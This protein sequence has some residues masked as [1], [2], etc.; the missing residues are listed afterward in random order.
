MVAP[1]SIDELVGAH[2][3]A[4]ARG[5]GLQY[6]TV[7]RT[8]TARAVHGHWT[9]NGDAHTTTVLGEWARVNG[10]DTQWIPE[11][12]PQVPGCERTAGDE[13]PGPRT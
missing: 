5:Q 12:A 10:T 9:E 3:L 2:G 13:P 6:D 8:Q 4:L 7:T 1:Q 11:G